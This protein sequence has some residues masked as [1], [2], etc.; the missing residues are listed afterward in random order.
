L[1]F[2]PIEK[3]NLLWYGNSTNS[4]WIIGQH[5]MGFSSASRVGSVLPVECF[6]KAET[7]QL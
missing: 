3:Q 1:T 4:H 6:V 2:Q 5:F 7:E